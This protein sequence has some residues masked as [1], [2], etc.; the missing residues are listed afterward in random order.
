MTTPNP[1]PSGGTHHADRPA[2]SP[3]TLPPLP[4]RYRPR[5]GVG[6][7]TD[8]PVRTSNDADRSQGKPG[9]LPEDTTSMSTDAPVN[10]RSDGNHLPDGQAETLAVARGR[11][12]RRPGAGRRPKPRPEAPPALAPE[13]SRITPSIGEVVLYHECMGYNQC[14]GQHASGLIARPGIVVWAG[15]TSDP[16]SKL[17]LSIVREDQLVL[18][19]GV[20]HAPAPRQGCWTHRL[21]PDG[22]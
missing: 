8:A 14:M 6:A 3:G 18:V 11:G 20:P 22:G 5:H 4:S 12:G 1:D 21:R 9:G 17:S 15:S 2:C 19:N 13:P 16:E 7:R 10:S